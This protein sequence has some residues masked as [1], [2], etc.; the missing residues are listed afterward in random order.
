MAL[1]ENR[2]SQLRNENQTVMSPAE[3]LAGIS[4]ISITIDGYCSDEEVLGLIASLNRMKLFRSY[5]NDVMR[6][7]FDRLLFLIK[8]RWI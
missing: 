8:K 3:A 5:S 6:K 4:L 1:F 7:L 2:F